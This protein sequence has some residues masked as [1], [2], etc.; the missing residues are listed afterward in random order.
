MSAGTSVFRRTILLGGIIF[1]TAA[2]PAQE[3]SLDEIPALR[4]RAVK[5]YIV[6]QIVDQNQQVI[7]DSEDSKVAL[8]GQPIG[9]RLTGDNLVVAVQF[10]PFLRP[11]GR[12]LLVALGQIWIN[13]PDEGM[14]FYTTMKT[15]PLEFGEQV[16][17]FPLGSMEDKN[18][19]Y[20][21]IKLMLEPYSERPPSTNARRERRN[22]PRP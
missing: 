2:L 7:L 22:A 6:S 21:E 17:F 4:E 18:E 12:H 13:I 15:I 20:I 16:Y 3:N 14:S 8:P 9:L 1:F 11:N 19:A 10:T 5:V